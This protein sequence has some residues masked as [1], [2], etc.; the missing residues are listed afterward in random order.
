MCDYKHRDGDDADGGVGGGGK[1]GSGCWGH[2]GDDQLVSMGGHM[3][4]NIINHG[5]GRPVYK[6]I[7][8]MAY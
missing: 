6:Y 4:I 3:L 5:Y 8:Y 7:Q 2:E 1:G